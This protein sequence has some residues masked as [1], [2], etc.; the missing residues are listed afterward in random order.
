MLIIIIFMRSNDMFIILSRCTRIAATCTENN[1]LINNNFIVISIYIQYINITIYVYDVQHELTC[2]EVLTISYHTDVYIF[3]FLFRILA[4][5]LTFTLIII[6]YSVS[7]YI[8]FVN[9]YDF[10]SP[11]INIIHWNKKIIYRYCEIVN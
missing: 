5:I 9:R 10:Q 3:R 8:Y 11:C 6:G 1:R 7:L 4:N 2:C